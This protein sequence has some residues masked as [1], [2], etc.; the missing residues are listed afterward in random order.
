MELRVWLFVLNNCLLFLKTYNNSNRCFIQMHLNEFEKSKEE[1]SLFL[2]SVHHYSA[3]SKTKNRI[4]LSWWRYARS[5]SVFKKLKAALV[6][7]ITE[8]FLTSAG[9]FQLVP[10]V[11]WRPG[12]PVCLLQ[13]FAG[14]QLL[15]G[16]VFFMSLCSVKLFP[17]F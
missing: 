16:A 10:L 6:L 17:I 7:V 13:S 14:T 2:F 8:L 11:N 12:T 9:D 3:L 1:F 5:T 4:Q 15:A